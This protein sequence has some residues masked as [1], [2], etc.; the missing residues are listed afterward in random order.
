M[1][2]ICSSIS[3]F[4]TAH[5]RPPRSLKWLKNGSILFVSFTAAKL[6]ENISHKF[7]KPSSSVNLGKKH[8]KLKGN[9]PQSNRGSVKC[10]V[11][12]HVLL[13]AHLASCAQAQ[14][15]WLPP[16]TQEFGSFL[17][18]CVTG[19]GRQTTVPC[20]CFSTYPDM[21]GSEEGEI[22]NIL[23][24]SILDKTASKKCTYYQ[25]YSLPASFCCLLIGY[26]SVWVTAHLKVRY[27]SAKIIWIRASLA[28]VA[29]DWK[30]SETACYFG[31]AWNEWDNFCSKH[32]PIASRPMYQGYQCKLRSLASL[33]SYQS[34]FHIT[35]Y[36]KSVFFIK[37]FYRELNSS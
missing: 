8:W 27:W 25:G 17:M 20:F 16:G 3:Q 1:G 29:F 9:M 5:W 22:E 2:G 26:V 6:A 21:Q 12:L 37:P 35:L 30:L 32:S 24:R 28:K 11:C 23:P 33:T 31:N 36:K 10:T 4:L 14:R 15:L 7:V 19:I 34:L 13:W 18:L